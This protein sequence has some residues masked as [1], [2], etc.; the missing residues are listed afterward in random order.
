MARNP[1][2]LTGVVFTVTT[3]AWT[4][5]TWLQARRIDRYG[6]RRFVAL[7]FAC[8]AVGGLLTLWPCWRACRRRSPS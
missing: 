4:I 5:G 8:I 6:P 1:L 2:A 3:I 7:G